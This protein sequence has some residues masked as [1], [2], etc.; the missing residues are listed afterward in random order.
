VTSEANR[1]A[2]GFRV[3]ITAVAVQG[4]GAYSSPHS[5]VATRIEVQRLARPEYKIEMEA[6]ISQSVDRI[7]RV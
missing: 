7:K 4:L 3:R 5:P 1:P 2:Q 6:V